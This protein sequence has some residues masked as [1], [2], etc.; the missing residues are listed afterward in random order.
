MRAHARQ[1]FLGLVTPDSDIPG[2][3]HTPI[4]IFQGLV[5]YPFLLVPVQDPYS[6]TYAKYMKV[7][8]SLGRCPGPEGERQPSPPHSSHVERGAA[9]GAVVRTHQSSI[10]RPRDSII[11]EPHAQRATPRHIL[12]RISNTRHHP[13]SLPPQNPNPRA[14]ATIRSPYT[15][16]RDIGACRSTLTRAPDHTRRFE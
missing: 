15:R 9:F 13:P 2:S 4:Q 7:Y 16:A 6:S 10:D 14:S 12:Q 3:G 11:G 1:F 8:A 5:E